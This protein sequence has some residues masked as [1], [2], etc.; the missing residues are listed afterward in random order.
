MELTEN[1]VAEVETE[2][3]MARAKAI[4]DAVMTKSVTA[5]DVGKLF[6]DLIEVCG[7]VRDALALFLDTNVGEIQADIDQRLEGAAAATIAATSATQAAA[8]ATSYLEELLAKLST[9][10]L[11]AP[12]VL[13]VKAPAE[14]TIR[15][16]MSPKIK[17]VTLPTFGIGGAICIGDNKAVEVLPN[18]VLTPIA[19]GVSKI[20]VVASGNTDLYK[21]VSIA[22]V[23]PRVRFAGGVMRLD[24]NGNIR[25]T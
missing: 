18:G 13:E 3:L 17:A 15:N 25:L 19:V 5:E 12:T 4:R 23:K 8:A 11:S 14:I 1:V 9:Q 21:Q 10:D 16:S 20:N 6:V 2:A 7:N 24:S 22:V